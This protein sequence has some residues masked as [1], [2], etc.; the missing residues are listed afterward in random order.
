MKF[1]STLMTAAFLSQAVDSQWVRGFGFWAWG[2]LQRMDHRL[3]E[4]DQQLATLPEMVPINSSIRVG[5]KTGYTTTEDTRWIEMKLPETALVDTIVMVPPLAK[6]A[7]AVV[8]G[9]GF[10]IRFKLEVF[11]DE[12]RSSIVMDQTQEDFPNPGCYPVVVRFPPQP[13]RSVRLTATEPW[14]ADGPEVLALAE[15]L[16]LS[17]RRNLA[18]NARVQSSSTRN[19]PRA[20]TRPNLVDMV[21]PLGLP[22]AP[23]VG[24]TLG[25][26]SEVATKSDVQKSITLT[27]PEIT[28][29]DEVRLLPVRRRDVPLWFDYGFPILYRVETATREDFS[30]ATLL[31][32]V[33]D[34]FY[35]S[36]GMNPVCIPAGGKAAR[37]IRITANKLWYRRNDYVFA[38]AEVQALKD[39][40][41]L[42][43][44]GSFSATDVLTGEEGAA[45]S[46][47]ALTDGLVENGR[48]IELPDWFSQ[49]EQR[50]AL[51]EERQGLMTGREALIQRTHQQMAY[52]GIGSVG[53]LTL[54]FGLLLWRQHSHRRRDAQ[55]MQDKLARDLHDEIGSNLGSITL[56]CSIAT[57]PDA[58]PESVQAD[59]SEIGRVAE[60]TANSMRDMVDL[61]RRPSP[62]KGRDW[63]DVLHSLTER[64]L[65]GLELDC[66]L[67]TTPLTKE[68]DIEMQREIYLFCKEVLHN[69]SRHA[70]ATRVRFYL[71][72]TATGLRIEIADNG[73]GFDTDQTS[74]GHG[75][76]NLRERAAAMH[77]RLH[78]SSKRGEGTVIH[79]DLPRT[80]RWRPR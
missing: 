25:Y 16:V 56:I 51:E 80:H 71:I 45:W 15:M 10:P 1:L 2:D 78:L 38:L 62:D 22:T 72:P 34:T 76:G 20:W 49:L 11:D 74:T 65:R 23:Q 54:C 5:L 63:L 29:L 50:R 40:I 7:N 69:I 8:A 28:E 12:G 67:P 52:G 60:E 47:A 79:L 24:G 27:L 68:P 57:Q 32:E 26:H 75:M 37:F 59:L 53:V 55:R 73:I 31:H 6:G 43:P 19:A 14:S 17:G 61:I 13:L 35:P 18:I 36:P 77:A 39:G 42:A 3:E 21:T 44:R 46:L 9:Y 48:L 33:T 41:N 30:D 66:A 4:L 70:G 58:T 64:L